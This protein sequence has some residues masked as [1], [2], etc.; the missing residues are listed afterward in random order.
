GDN[1]LGFV[2]SKNS[3]RRQLNESQRAMV[4]ARLATLALGTNQH[5]KCFVP[6]QREAA[7]LLQVSDV[8]VQKARKV[9]R[10]AA[11]AI[12]EAVEQGA[13]TLTAALPFT[14]LPKA[15]QGHTL[16]AAQR[17]RPG[18][19]LTATHTRAVVQRAQGVATGTAAVTDGQPPH[20]AVQEALPQ[21]AITGPTPAVAQAIAQATDHHVT[22]EAT[23]GRRQAGDPAT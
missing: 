23:A 15:D 18:K 10:D 19:P 22:L 21:H 4:A 16:A 3:L 17:D 5:T 12:V 20:G 13:L 14:H 8:T 1:P 6:S 2:V 9:H 11:P 7:A